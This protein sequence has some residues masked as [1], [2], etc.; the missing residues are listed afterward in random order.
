[1][2]VFAI[3]NSSA[4]RAERHSDCEILPL[5][6]TT[7]DTRQLIEAATRGAALLFKRGRLYKKAGVMLDDIQPNSL[8]QPSLFASETA[9]SGISKTIDAINARMGSDT[10]RFAAVDIG[11]NWR[12]NQ[13]YRSP[14]YSTNWKELPIA[15]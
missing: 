15:Q 4:N 13:R 8:R 10:L 9:G 3:A 11:S 12:M 6:G 14:K 5:A 1:V 7:D 2:T